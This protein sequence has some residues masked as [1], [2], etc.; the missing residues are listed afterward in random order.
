MI[1]VNNIRVTKYSNTVT[2]IWVNHWKT[3]IPGVL[4]KH[5]HRLGTP[6]PEFQ[7]K[8]LQKQKCYWGASYMMLHL[9]GLGQK[10][11]PWKDL[12]HQDAL[13]KAPWR[14]LLCSLAMLS[15]TDNVKI[16]SWTLCWPADILNE[17]ALICLVLTGTG[18]EWAVP[19]CDPGWSA[20]LPVCWLT[21][22]GS[23][24][25]TPHSFLVLV[26]TGGNEGS[27][28]AQPHKRHQ[29]GNY[30]STIL[31]ISSSFL[32]FPKADHLQDS[33][34]GG[35]CTHTPPMLWKI[36]SCLAS[37]ASQI[38]VRCGGVG[39]GFPRKSM[40]GTRLGSF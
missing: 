37:G 20:L 18:K 40:L 33:C 28:T 31:P 39:R 23:Q 35:D 36:A 7:K 25:G 32:Y 1:I 6:H 26:S 38:L 22:L 24:D 17:P 9:T 34:I 15:S 27:W 3:W 10:M 14:G 12:W 8:G 5:I 30:F 16:A 19:S 13:L 29:K 2:S 21:E 4:C 11:W